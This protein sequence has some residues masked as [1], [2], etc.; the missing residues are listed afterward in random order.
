MKE[1]MM[2]AGV[3]IGRRFKLKEKELFLNQ[4]IEM[5]E[6]Q[7][8]SYEFQTKHSRLLNICNLV[9]GD[10]KHASTIVAC[11]YDTP[12]KT[13]LPGFKYYPFNPSFNT[14][15]ET[16]NL[17]AQCLGV[18][19]CFLLIF[20]WVKN[21]ESA[22]TWLKVL[23]VAGS[24]MMGYAG[25]K[26]LKPS[27]NLVNFSRN[28]AAVACVLKLMETVQSKKTAYVFLDQNCAS[29]EGAKLLKEHVSD[30]QLVILLDNL[31]SG[32]KTVVAHKA[33]VNPENLLHEGW[34]DKVYDDTANM[35]GIFQ[36]SVMISCGSIKDKQFYV[37]NTGTKKDVEVNMERLVLITET[38]KKKLEE[39]K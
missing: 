1:K 4:V 26:F 30:H 32:D 23:I 19:C 18:F 34:I 6:K 5:A 37:C 22:Q 16:K 15:E 11:A 20:L 27:G 17:I 33:T 38:I 25:Y 36:R 7:H 10:I 24:I 3:N 29:Y 9:V 39:T 28:S 31:A 2:F 12:A 8:L 35:L 13:I 14:K 21:F